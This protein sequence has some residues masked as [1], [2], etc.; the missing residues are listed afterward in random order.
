MTN[1][2]YRAYQRRLDN[3]RSPEDVQP[4]L[5][6]LSGEDPNDPD[7][8]AIAEMAATLAGIR[9]DSAGPD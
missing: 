8:E 1:E 9:L 7:V 2:R 6:D 3:V 4:I 5:V